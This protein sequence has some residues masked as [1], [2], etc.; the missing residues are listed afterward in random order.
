MTAITSR[1]E[2][3]AE[4]PPSF[5]ARWTSRLALFCVLL[6]VAALFLHRVVRATDADCA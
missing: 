2:Y 5:L 3:A 1:I 4:Q 6:L